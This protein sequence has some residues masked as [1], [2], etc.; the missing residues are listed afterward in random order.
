VAGDGVAVI[1]VTKLLRVESNLASTVEGYSYLVGFEFCDRAW[2]TIDN[3]FLC[4]RSAKL[5]AITFGEGS[6]GLVVNTDTGKA[7]GVIGQS[8]AISKA[9][10]NLV[11]LV[12]GSYNGCIVAYLNLKDFAGAVVADNVFAGSVGIGEGALGAGDA[13]C[14]PDGVRR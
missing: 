12:V 5:N 7:R 6:L 9:N 4:E 14:S 3:P 10:R 1:E 8:A 11:L 2:F 13:N